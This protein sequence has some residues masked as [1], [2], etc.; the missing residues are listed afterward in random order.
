[1]ETGRT[2]FAIFLL[3]LVALAGSNAIHGLLHVAQAQAATGV[4]LG[5]AQETGTTSELLVANEPSNTVAMGQNGTPWQAS[6]VSG[7]TVQAVQANGQNVLNENILTVNQ[8]QKMVPIGLS[9]PLVAWQI[10]PDA[11]F[12]VATPAPTATP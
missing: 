9:V 5:A 12:S 4:F 2:L 7:I 3:V 11:T 1:M 10:A 6:G 8:Q